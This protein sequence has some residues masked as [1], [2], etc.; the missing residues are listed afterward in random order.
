MRIA[1]PLRIALTILLVMK[2]GLSAFS[3]DKNGVSPNTISLPKGPGSLE[4]LGE[5]F[6]PN[7][8]TGT[9]KYSISLAVPPGTAGQTPGLALSYE[10]GGGNGTLGFGWTIA[11][12]FVQRRTDKGIP[13]YPGDIPPTAAD[14][15]SARY[16][17]FINDMKEELV[18]TSEGY[19]FCKNEGAFIRYRPNGAA[20]QATLPDGTLQDLGLS[21]NARIA[22]GTNRVFSWLI[23][24][25]TDLHG[26]TIVYSYTNFVDDHNLNQKYLASIQYGPG[27][28]PWANSH[29]VQ[30]LYEDRPDWFE[31]CRAGFVVRTGKRVKQ[32]VIGTQGPV[33]PGH[34]A[35]DFN[36]DGIPDCLDRRY[37]LQYL[38]YAGTNSHWSL[39]AKVIQ[40]GADGVSTLPSPGF[41]YNVCNPPDTVSAAGKVIP[42]VNEP[43]LVMD[44]GS[45]NV[46]LIDLNGDAL[47][48]LLRTFP[49][50][51]PQMAFTNQGMRVVG[52]TN[53][54][55]WSSGVQMGGDPSAAAYTL[56]DPN[57]HLADM[58]GD[59]LSDLVLKSGG[60]VFYFTNLG[61]FQWGTKRLMQVTDIVPP[62]PFADS[63][64]RTADIDFDKNIDVIQSV[65]VGGEV[66]YFVWLNL[67]DNHFAARKSQTN[68]AG[69]M[70]SSA[71]VQVAD[72]NGDRVPDVCRIATS[73]VSVTAGLG[74]GKFADPVNVAL[75]GGIDSSL[76]AKATLQ[77]VT[78][79]GLADLVVDRPVPG[80]LWYWINLGN[81]SFGARK[82]VVN[83]PVVSSVNTVTRWADLNGNG[84]TDLIYSDSLATPKL[85]TIDLGDLLVGGT[86]PNALLVI[87]NGLG[88][89]TSVHYTSSTAMRVQDLQQG[90]SWT[91]GLPLSL[92]VVSSVTNLDSLGHTYATHFYYHDGYYDPVEKQFRGFSRVEQEDVGD[93]T[94]PSL[95]TRSYF[96]T[97]RTHEARKG[98]LLRLTTMQSDLG[99]FD[100]AATEWLSTPLSLY[101]G[102][103]GVPVSYVF[104]VSSTKII[105]ELGQGIERRLESEF[106]YDRFGNKTTN[107]DYGIVVNGDR[108]AFDDERISVTEYAVNTNAWILHHPSRSQIQD[109]HGVVLSREAYFYDDETFSGVNA[110]L[111]TIGNLTMRR[112]WRD[113]ANPNAYVI[114]GRTRFDPYGNATLLL[115]P[116][117]TA[118]LSLG[119]GRA[120][121]YD[122]RFHTFPTTETIH[123]GG[124]NAPLVFQASY[125]EGFGTVSTSTDFN[126]NVTTYGYDVFARF[127]HVIKPLDTPAYPSVEYDYVLA[128]PVGN[129]GLVNYVETRMLDKDPQLPLPD[130]RAHYFI[131][132]QFV[133]GMGRS[134]MTKTEAEPAA[135]SSTPRVTIQGATAFNARLKPVMALNPCFST[136]TGSLEDQLTYESIEAPG[137][138]GIFQELGTLVSLNLVQAHK[139]VTLFDPTLRPLVVTNAD[140]TFRRN[141]YE[142]LLTRS[143]DEN[144]TDPASTYFGASMAHS[145]DG[146]GRLIQVDEVTRMSDDGTRGGSLAP[147]TTRYEYDLNDQLT[148]I[149]DSQNNRKMFAYDGLKRK[150]FMNDPDRGVMHFA[151]DDASNLIETTDAKGQRIAFAYDGANR[152]RSEKYFDGKPAPRWRS[153]QN[154]EGQTN[155]VV[156][157]YDFPIPAL[158][159]G[160]NT[161]ATARNV[162]GNLAWVEDL[163]G[164]EHTSYDERGR[165]ECVI[166]RVPD[167]LLL[168]AY[169]DAPAS[170]ASYTTRFAYD[171]LDRL[172]NL[173]YPDAD[174]LRYEYNDRNLVS[175][176]PGGPSGSII[177][178]IQ[179]QPSAQMGE[180]NYGNGVR[181]SYTY[182]SR[183]RLKN[184]LTVSQPNGVNQQFINFGYDF[185]GISNIKTISD[186][187]PASAVSAGDPRRNTQ[188]FQY[189]DL[190][191]LTRAQYSFALPGDLARNDGEINYRYDRIGNML[192]QTSTLTNHLERGLPV[193]NLGQMESGGA[194]GRWNRSGRASTDPPGPHAL[195]SIQNSEATNQTRLYPYDPN[196]NMT[197]IDGLVCTWDFKDRLIAVENDEMQASYA[198]D[199]SD[200]RILKDV[201][202]KPGSANATNHD[203]RITTLY[204]NKY[205]EVREHDAPTKYVW[206]GAT[207]VAKVTGSL[208]ANLRVQRLRVY[209]GWN[210]VSLA[211]TAT[212]AL[213]QLSPPPY[214]LIESG[215]KWD[216]LSRTWILLEPGENLPAGS[217]L[218]LKATM[219]TVL[220]V[221]GSY[222][223]PTNITIAPGGDFIGSGSLENWNW[224]ST[225]LSPLIKS[226]VGYDTLTRSWLSWLPPPFELSNIPKFVSPGAV[227]FAMNESSLSFPA[228]EA[229]GG[230]RYY[231]SD[232]L[233]S[234][235]CI[236]DTQGALVETAAYFPFGIPRLEKLLSQLEERFK[237][238]EK[239]RDKESG[240]G[241]FEAR[242]LASALGRFI[243]VDPICAAI[244]PSWIREPQRMNVYSFCGANP[245]SRMDPL[246]LDYADNAVAFGVGL[247]K[248]VLLGVGV[249]LVA[250]AAAPIV[251]AVAAAG[252]VGAA[253]VAIGGVALAAASGY[254]LGKAGYEVVTGDKLDW[255]LQNVGKLS[256]EQR[257][258]GAGMIT[259]GILIGAWNAR[260][261]S[262]TTAS[263]WGRPGLRENDWV[264]PGEAN[265]SNY[266]LSFK[267]EST[268]FNEKAAIETGETFEVASGSLKWP[269][270]I[271]SFK[272]LFGQ[273]QYIPSAGVSPQAMG[274]V[275]GMI[276]APLAADL[277]ENQKP[278][279][280]RK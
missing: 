117:G 22:A 42:G 83:L 27:A 126:G 158:S 75:P 188:L 171:L 169:P 197:N 252:A 1:K 81:Y 78:G 98:K 11:T 21:G 270:G 262:A 92:Q 107:A 256:T 94:A 209:P 147:W 208:S 4:G 104:P 50:G 131:S 249:T 113:P 6:Q 18:P 220:S 132:R 55:S 40:V 31:D 39:L 97:G 16:S 216:P 59:G 184:L 277:T 103:N 145:S 196:G 119:H 115:D 243:R 77:D 221:Q 267:W 87:S 12:P 73:F 244:R 123:L 118:D 186:L 232:H 111:I 86:S 235:T 274:L 273:R 61:N 144:Q 257:F 5:S 164:E 105:H 127:V 226:I 135:G 180:I 130:H 70:F 44:G 258:E 116:L 203:A 228:P 190:Y 198:Y 161:S 9:A 79:D 248:G 279:T 167:L 219:N 183:Q 45:T 68:L 114:A 218:W 266:R 261:S 41:D 109:E 125:D 245:V 213:T 15:W 24:K 124:T 153:D 201:S 211:V 62:S 152:I 264:M 278:T 80:E 33:L 47:P 179:Y 28:P 187:R 239:E 64:V 175:R 112:E 163:S 194:M 88:R 76:I 173:T 193:A 66:R 108:S 263:R 52:G 8:N 207:R 143:F 2:S 247:G 178:S 254:G 69:F 100:D 223:A 192:A 265:Q 269:R 71:G 139:T 240:L 214:Q 65:L 93:S 241:H 129:T 156:Y 84:S 215:H 166:K 26:N 165:V 120:V 227:V 17:S 74:Y 25:E 141:V 110:G 204:I 234:S 271:E 210:L 3:A 157:H 48:D 38:D 195:T 63:T 242:F 251:A 49:G 23:E 233:A 237:F 37:D 102:T 121:T 58:T 56:S 10:A 30:F 253:T 14:D 82:T 146:L 155:S 246:G 217:V 29:F 60:S 133:D 172:T 202:Y 189:D 96:D 272:G 106:S 259:G 36:L 138:Q 43:A 89:V 137:W 174:Q 148:R 19:Y 35:G 168:S 275:S 199:Y 99:V 182:D 268:P 67:G 224:H 46:E 122:T 20:W 90:I 160:D 200:R 162:K 222:S 72:F 238:G 170:L 229:S 206:N 128:L 159:Q 185:D 230:I 151:Y 13:L 149:T 134:L 236:S 191:R 101:L 280:N 53:A 51:T 150:L 54:I 276:T 250:V 177:S 57:V 260:G 91:N 154:L 34:L 176:I 142:P 7:L 32:I 140:G 225:T 95:I 212:N 255:K 181:T 85:R 231:H 205:F 136:L